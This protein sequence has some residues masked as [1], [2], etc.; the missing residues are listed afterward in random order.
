MDS[1][2]VINQN[3]NLQNI[4]RLFRLVILFAAGFLLTISRYTAIRQIYSL[5]RGSEDFDGLYLVPILTFI[6]LW[7]RRKKLFSFQWKT[8]WTALIPLGIILIFQALKTPTGARMQ[9]LLLIV[10]IELT[11]LTIFGLS[12]FRYVTAPLMLSILAIPAPDWLWQKMTLVTQYL[13]LK[14]SIFVYSRVA[15]ISCD[16]FW[17]FLHTCQKWVMVALQCSGVRSL[18]GLCIVSWFLFLRIRLNPIAILPLALCIP[19][20]ALSLNVCRILLTLT[21]RDHGL[22]KYTIEFWHGLA[23]IIV[24]FAGFFI[25]SRLAAIAEIKR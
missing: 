1:Q 16:G 5:W 21:L 14:A 9:M 3:V 8:F 7:Q 11:I 10:S 17:I 23:G 15:P 20:I 4:N 19:L 18:L 2:L 13:S 6:V 24:F 12:A 25:V 22:E